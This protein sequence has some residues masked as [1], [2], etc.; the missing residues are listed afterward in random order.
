MGPVIYLWITWYLASYQTDIQLY[1]VITWKTVRCFLLCLATRSSPSTTNIT[2]LFLFQEHITYQ[3]NF[4]AGYVSDAGS[5]VWKVNFIDESE[6]EQWLYKVKTKSCFD[7]NIVPAVNDRIITLSTCSY[8]FDNARFV[9]HG[10]LN[11]YH[12]KCCFDKIKK[13]IQ[14][15]LLWCYIRA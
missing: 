7:S 13:F 5:D 2:L 1:M 11:P 15:T 10:I 14:T 9:V 3:I 8:E 6:F 4:F 12:N